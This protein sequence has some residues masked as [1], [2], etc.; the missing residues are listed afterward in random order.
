MEENFNFN[1]PLEL[2]EVFRTVNQLAIGDIIIGPEDEP[3]FSEE[4]KPRKPEIKEY[5]FKHC[6]GW[7]DVK[8]VKEYMYPDDWKEHKGPKF[9]LKVDGN[10]DDIIVLGNYKSM[11]EHWRMFRNKYPLYKIENGMA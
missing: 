8:S 9:Y 2:T 6:L 4:A 7:E 10:A 1:D 3:E 5:A 11:T